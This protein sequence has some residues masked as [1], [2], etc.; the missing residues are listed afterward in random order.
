M[1]KRCVSCLLLENDMFTKEICKK[2]G[3]IIKGAKEIE[4]LSKSSGFELNHGSEWSATRRLSIGASPIDD[5]PTTRTRALALV[6]EE[7][8]L[9]EEEVD[10]PGVSEVRAIDKGSGNDLDVSHEFHNRVELCTRNL[11]KSWGHTQ[12]ATKT[13]W[14]FF[15]PNEPAQLDTDPTAYGFGSLEVA[16]ILCHASK[17]G[18][19]HPEFPVSKDEDQRRHDEDI[20]SWSASLPKGNQGRV[21]KSVF[22]Y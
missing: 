4:W 11:R 18:A 12:K 13:S 8:V 10:A 19:L 3:C 15:V 1:V 7:L 6:A 17:I 14:A 5:S 2:I 21:P 9:E 22:F 20:D 16:C